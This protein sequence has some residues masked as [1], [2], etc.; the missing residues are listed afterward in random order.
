MKQIISKFIA[1]VYEKN[2][3]EADSLLQQIINE[4]VKSKI[5]KVIKGDDEKTTEKKKDD[6]NVAKKKNSTKMAP[7]KAK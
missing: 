7:K 2:Y 3:A 1:T 6:K 5:K 4:K